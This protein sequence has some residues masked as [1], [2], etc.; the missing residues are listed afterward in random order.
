M[1]DLSSPKTNRRKHFALRF[2]V[3]VV[4]VSALGVSY[5]LMR[6]PDLVP[7]ISPQIGDTGH[8]LAMLV[9]SGWELQPHAYLQKYSPP[10]GRYQWWYYVW[11][12]KP[13]NRMPRL[14]KF[15]FGNRTE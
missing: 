3:F 13:V 7:W 12:V 11:R 6:P 8:H 14:L 10:A 4:A 1:N 2:A 9:P 15:V 5:W